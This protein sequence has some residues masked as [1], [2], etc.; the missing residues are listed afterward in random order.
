MDILNKLPHYLFFFVVLIGPLISFHEFGHFWVARKLGVKILRFSVGF[1]KVLWSKQKSKN[2][3]EYVISAIPLGGYVKMVDERESH[4][5]LEDMPYA[6][7]R[8]PLSVRT[9][10]V[11][12]GPVF[13]LLL[14]VC[15]FWLVLVIGESGMKPL[16]GEIKPGT[17]AGNAGLAEG[18]EIVAVD[19]KPVMTWAEA[20]G[21]IVTLAMN[22]KI[23]IKVSVKQ[24][25]SKSIEHQLI[26]EDD[27]AND[28]E[29]LYDRLGL[30]PWMPK[31]KPLVDKIIPGGAAEKAG[32]LHDDLVLSA[33]G[34]A[35][36]NWITW[37]DYV[38]KR[39]GMAIKL[40]VERQGQ[41]K[42]LSITPEV[43][44]INCN[45]E[46]KIG[47]MV[48]MPEGLTQSLTIKHALS[49]F[50]AFPAAFK[51][52][53]DY[54][55]VTLKMMGKL[56]IGKASLKN[57]S[58]PITIAEMAGQTASMGLEH[59]IKLMAFVS[60]SLGVLNLL[61]IPVLDGGH[62]FFFGIEALRRKPMPEKAQLFFQQIG[63]MMLFLLMATA[64]FMDTQRLF[65]CN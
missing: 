20:I 35:I 51:M 63:M 27:D 1:G 48:Q 25:D 8:K 61:P 58:G 34:N 36:P 2:E 38:K 50:D 41:L 12:A 3:T 17:V 59:F 24:G 10:I 52:T 18:D 9:A 46:G 43:V 6:F 28:S 64:I 4:V 49:P 45:S 32:L 30:Q 33:D 26:L 23:S 65:P 22:N 53:Y 16:L 15:L 55:L 31:L 56:L 21:A 39:P 13:N 14:A 11:A 29:K 37:V 54:S 60:V 57:L 44:K 62:L 7:N 5:A 47:A 19:G 42:T 40:I